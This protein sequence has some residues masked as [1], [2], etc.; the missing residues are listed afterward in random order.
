[1]HLSEIP[2]MC[3]THVYCNSIALWKAVRVH[4]DK[5]RWWN[6]S[7]AY[8]TEESDSN[9]SYTVGHH[10][11]PGHQR[12]S[13]PNIYSSIYSNKIKINTKINGIKNLKM[14]LDS[15]RASTQKNVLQWPQVVSAPST[16]Q[17]PE[18]YLAWA[19]SCTFAR[20]CTTPL[21]V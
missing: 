7:F 11:L 1:M 4:Q 20:V 5:Q 16:L 18:N 19:V 13:N 10:H 6:L 8:M 12:A 21:L 17:P 3:F 2:V 15:R 14:K 9:D